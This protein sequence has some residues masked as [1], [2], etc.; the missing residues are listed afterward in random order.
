MVNSIFYS[1]KNLFRIFAAMFIFSF[2]LTGCYYDKE[3][4]L[5]PTAENCDTTGVMTYSGQI[6]PIMTG[7]CNVCH[8][9]ANPSGGVV[10][11]T[12][13]GLKVVALDGRLSA[14]VNWTGPVQMPQG[15]DKLSAC[16]LAKINKWVVAG[17]PNN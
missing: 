4:E 3:N 11:S 16:N 5:Y 6:A 14:A 1:M 12:Y 13:D 10:T 9:G 8:S 17:A 7:N 15:T 2:F